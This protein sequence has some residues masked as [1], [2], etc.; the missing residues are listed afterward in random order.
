MLFPYIPY[1]YSPSFVKQTI[2]SGLNLH[3]GRGHLYPKH[4]SF[5]QNSSCGYIISSLG[6]RGIRSPLA[7]NHQHKYEVI[8]NGSSVCCKS[9]VLCYR[10]VCALLPPGGMFG[11]N[12]RRVL[13]YNKYL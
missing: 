3:T 8:I 9:F 13:V 11:K 4:G 5:V 7:V 12:L 6:D 2:L 10:V 1:V